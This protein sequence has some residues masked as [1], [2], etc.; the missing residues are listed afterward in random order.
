[1]SEKK[2]ITIVQFASG[3]G[4][5]KKQR[6]ILMGLGLRRLHKPRSLEDN[7]SVRGMLAHVGHLVSIVA[8]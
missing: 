4:R 3:I 2:K 8:E 5:P 6:A 7:A 1:M